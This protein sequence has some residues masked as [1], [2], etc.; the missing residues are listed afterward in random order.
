MF[1]YFNIWPLLDANNASFKFYKLYKWRRIFC[2]ILL[3]ETKLY[4][5]EERQFS[6]YRILSRDFLGWVTMV[7]LGPFVF[8]H[9]TMEEIRM[10]PFA[11]SVC[12]LCIIEICV[13][14]ASDKPDWLSRRVVRRVC[15]LPTLPPCLFHFPSVYFVKTLPCFQNKKWKKARML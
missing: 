13:S 9:W 6:F 3:D 7:T 2:Y 15:S 11:I 14:N 10:Y 5:T 1:C 12:S 8:N 4:W